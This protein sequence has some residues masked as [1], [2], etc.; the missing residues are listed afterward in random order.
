MHGA[1]LPE[2]PSP[3]VV[4]LLLRAG[5]SRETVMGMGRWKAQELVDLL[6]ADGGATGEDRRR[7]PRGRGSI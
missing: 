6:G 4:R 3:A 1:R 2:P 7:P 5:L